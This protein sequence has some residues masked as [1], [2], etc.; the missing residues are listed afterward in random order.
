MKF[1]SRLLRLCS[2][3]AVSIFS[4][5]ASIITF[6]VTGSL[7]DGDSISGTIT[8]NNTA[9]TATAAD[10]T[11]SAPDSFNMPIIYGQGTGFFGALPTNYGIGLQNTAD[12]ENFNFIFSTSTLVGYTGS[13][14]PE[15]NLFNLTTSTPG[16]SIV[17]M[18]L[19]QSTVPEPGSIV[20]TA[21]GALLMLLLARRVRLT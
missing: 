13:S 11:F 12:T 1:A 5:S 10:V 2:L 7:T 6:N 4:S 18:T 3:A 17:T 15:G 16:A 9:G 19:A 14:I 20:L 21:S 8:I